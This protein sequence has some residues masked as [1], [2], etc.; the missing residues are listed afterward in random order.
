MDLGEK[1]MERLEFK[2][3]FSIPLPESVSSISWIAPFLNEKHAIPV[4]E[5]VVTMWVVSALLIIFSVIITRNLK[6]IPSGVQSIL[7]SG[8]EFLENFSKSQFGKYSPVLGHY[9]GS[10]FLFLL[11]VNIIPVIT[12]VGI[13]WFGGFEPPFEIKP[14]TRDIN[15]TACLA[16]ITIILVL[17]LGI[18]ARGVK[19]WVKNLFHP[20]G[21][22]VVFNLMDFVTRPL[23]LCL[24]LFGN[25]LG[26]FVL[27]T[28]IQI[29]MPIIIPA[30]FSLYFDLFDGLIQAVVFCFL[31]TLYI[32]EAVTLE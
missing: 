27:M 26:G 30:P 7:E 18:H 6:R 3:V 25:I 16:L 24:R 13:P 2:E 12:P 8:I 15:L 10:V 19:G 22:M 32:N 23:S 4:T 14:P 29:I 31:T 1:I 21:F 11:A 17:V 28:L 9:I 5:T 20:V